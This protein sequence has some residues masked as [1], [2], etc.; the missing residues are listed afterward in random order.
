MLALRDRSLTMGADL[1][2][3][4]LPGQAWL[5]YLTPPMTAIRHDSRGIAGMAADLVTRSLGAALRPY[6]VT[7]EPMLHLGGS[8]G[9]AVSAPELLF[10]KITDVKT[11]VLGYAYDKPWGSARVCVRTGHPAAGGGANGR[12]RYWVG[13][14]RLQERDPGHPHSHRR[15]ARFNVLGR[16]PFQS[17]ALWNE[18]YNRV[19]DGGTKGIMISAMSALDMAIWDIKGKAVGRPNYELLGGKL[20]D[21]A[22]LRDGLLLHPGSGSGAGRR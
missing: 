2:V 19:K 21:G 22:R 9:C 16:D 20:R 6:Q 11:Y 3:V 14:G 13:H 5:D 1:A 7:F 15:G 8:C 18:M 10:M 4:A 12:G 17:E